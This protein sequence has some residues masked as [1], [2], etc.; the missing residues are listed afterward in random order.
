M[1]WS[2]HWHNNSMLP[3]SE[4]THK[5]RDARN[6]VSRTHILLPISYSATPVLD[7]VSPTHSRLSVGKYYYCLKYLLFYFIIII[8]YDDER[9]RVMNNYQIS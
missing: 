2:Q 7:S 8:G 9:V 1:M 6:V 3:G 4:A 5:R